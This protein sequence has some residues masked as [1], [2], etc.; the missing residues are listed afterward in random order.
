[1]VTREIGSTV[2]H[3]LDVDD[4]LWWSWNR[5]RWTRALT[6]CMVVVVWWMR[7]VMM[8]MVMGGLCAR[9]WWCG[10]SIEPRR[11][12]GT[13][14][15]S[16]A[17]F[18]RLVVM[19]VMT[20]SHVSTRF[21]LGVGW[22]AVL[23]RMVVMVVAAWMNMLGPLLPTC[24]GQRWCYTTVNTVAIR[25][26][27]IL[28]C[29]FG[30]SAALRCAPDHLQILK[31]AAAPWMRVSRAMWKWTLPGR[32]CRAGPRRNTGNAATKPRKHPAKL[33][34]DVWIARWS[35]WLKG[36]SLHRL[37]Q[38]RRS[39]RPTIGIRSEAQKAPL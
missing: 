32:R 29:P 8:V 19:M 37:R 25:N 2:E 39:S 35:N 27:I 28:L 13:S 31:V 5:G 11:P 23:V 21:A 36:C 9:S 20:G 7:G 3:R 10:C 4:N 38:R 24:C 34:L 16:R 14:S 15:R 6:G 12:K 18:V 1:M 17:F 22:S 33:A 30:P 26:A